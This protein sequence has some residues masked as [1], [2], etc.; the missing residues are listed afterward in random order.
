MECFGTRCGL[1]RLPEGWARHFAVDKTTIAVECNPEF[2]RARANA[3]NDSHVVSAK[4]FLGNPLN[5]AHLPWRWETLA[6]FGTM[7][8]YIKKAA[9]VLLDLT[10]E[11][12][13]PRLTNE[14]YGAKGAPEDEER[15]QAPPSLGLITG[16][17]KAE[18]LASKPEAACRIGK[19]LSSTAMT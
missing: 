4:S 9:E 18:F 12:P 16:L 17:N 10:I 15:S 19:R 14:M 6:D 3:G 1:L 8:E 5:A 7:F 2:L 11:V 13:L